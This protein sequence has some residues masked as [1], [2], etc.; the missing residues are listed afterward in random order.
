MIALQTHVRREFTFKHVIPRFNARNLG[1]ALFSSVPA[2]A[3]YIAL[4]E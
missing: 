3:F 4:V 1:Y 2:V